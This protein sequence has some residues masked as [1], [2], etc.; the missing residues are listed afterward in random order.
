MKLH[1][2]T[3]WAMAS[4]RQHT[5]GLRELKN[6]LSAYVRLVRAGEHV[7]VTDRGQVVAELLPPGAAADRQQHPGL[8][9][10]H[11]RGLIGAVIANSPAVYARL[12]KSPKAGRAKRLLDAVRAER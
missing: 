3:S 7:Q 8:G 11:R 1:D 5:V 6:R 12:R 10:L 9:A 2:A 4:I